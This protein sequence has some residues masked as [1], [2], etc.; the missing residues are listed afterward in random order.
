M[1]EELN[2]NRA[3]ETGLGDVSVEIAEQVDENVHKILTSKLSSMES[4]NSDNYNKNA[5]TL[6]KVL[7][8]EFVEL[9]EGVP[10]SSAIYVISENTIYISKKNF[11]ATLVC[12]ERLHMA[13]ANRE[14]NITGYAG[15]PNLFAFN[16]AATQWLTLSAFS[17]NAEVSNVPNGNND[18]VYVTK[19]FGELVRKYGEDKMYNGYFEA[20]F[21]KFINGLSE[22][23]KADVYKSI[24]LMNANCTVYDVFKDET[25]LSI[26]PQD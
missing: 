21:N 22:D 24:E 20:D 11:S 18:Y 13:S 23:E 9:K 6:K 26:P 5:G 4:F 19:L 14:K 2:E 15:D 25:Q 7:L 3:T 17:P 16:E 10:F 8:D 1:T 12:H